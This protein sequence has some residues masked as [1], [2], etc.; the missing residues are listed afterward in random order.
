MRRGFMS[1]R[2]RLAID[3]CEKYHV[4][5]ISE[6]EK[7][8]IKKYWDHFGICIKDFSWHRMYYYVTGIHDPRFVPDL[9]AGLIIYEY[10]NDSSCE[11]VWRDK[12]M[13]DRLL[14]NVPMPNTYAKRIR[15]RFYV[16]DSCIG[17]QDDTNPDYEGIARSIIISLSIPSVI[18]IKNTRTTGFGRGV[19]K[20]TITSIEDLISALKEWNDCS[21][22]IVQAF[23]KQHPVLSALNESSSNMIRV[24]SWRHNDQV[25][26]LFAAARV[27][28]P[29]AVT[30][31]SFVN[32]EERVQLVSISNNGILGNKLY[33][34]DGIVVKELPSNVKI[35]GFEKIVSVVKEN[36]LR[37]DRFDIVGWDF[38]VDESDNPI[39]FEWNIQWPGTILYQYINGPLYGNKTDEILEFLKNQKNRDN[40]IPC[41]MK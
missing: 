36:H 32:G 17:C 8:E 39:C 40:Y 38:T 20:Y 19:R 34:Q 3:Y 14:P 7:N 16:N 18:I 9:I 41:Y 10:Y 27:G 11:D 31:V 35:P 29:G 28:I 13:F 22:Y 24:C 6:K 37:I 2:E 1:S 5:D 33:N 23:I 30:D 25:D 4:P 15:K 21:D 12:N 26:I